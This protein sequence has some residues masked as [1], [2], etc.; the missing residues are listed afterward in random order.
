MKKLAFVLA[1]VV[2]NSFSI[3]AQEQNNANLYVK[4]KDDKKPLIMVNGKK[5]D[6]PMDLIDP[7]KI[8]SVHILKGKEAE[9]LYNTSNGVIL[10]TTKVDGKATYSKT[11]EKSK[12]LKK[13]I[14]YIDGK[15][16]SQAAL[17]KLDPEKIK[18]M[19]VLKGAEAIKKHNSP[20]G[21]II[22]N[23]KEK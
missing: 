5:F 2:L 7:S 16:S 3:S 8:E 4:V 20:G 12:N 11:T 18:K 15:L 17:D 9:A 14:I 6:F 1:L 19:E 21:V 23:T 22:V 10:V 13:P